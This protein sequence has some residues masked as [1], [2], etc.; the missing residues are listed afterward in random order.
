[1]RNKNN[2]NIKLEMAKTKLLK[3]Y[4]GEYTFKSR[5][6]IQN[7]KT[8]TLVTKKP[9]SPH[10]TTVNVSEGNIEHIDID[11]KK[12]LEVFK[13]LNTK[14]ENDYLYLH[15]C[16]IYFINTWIFKKNKTKYA[17]L[18]TTCIIVFFGFVFNI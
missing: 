10:S 17:K 7:D 12:G 13:D 11:K 18:F 6:A 9:T 8:S 1:M 16:I 5:S 14:Y 4:A 15:I 2:A 3:F